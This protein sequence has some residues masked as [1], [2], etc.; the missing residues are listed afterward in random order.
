MSYIVIEEDHI[1]KVVDAVVK[2]QQEGFVPCGG[3]TEA[4]SGMYI[5]AMHKELFNKDELGLKKVAPTKPNINFEEVK[6]H[7]FADTL[8]PLNSQLMVKYS[9]RGKMQKELSL[10]EIKTASHY[11]H[12]NVKLALW[13]YLH[14]HDML[15]NPQ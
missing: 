15:D 6:I 12:D 4:L 8:D 14:T 1:S 10:P 3:I 13:E 9:I 7:A 5:Q 2:W 11:N